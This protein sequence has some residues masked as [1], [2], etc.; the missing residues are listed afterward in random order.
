[1]PNDNP[2]LKQ[3]HLSSAGTIRQHGLQQGWNRWSQKQIMARHHFGPRTEFFAPMRSII[4]HVFS[5]W[6]FVLKLGALKMS[7]LII[8][9]PIKIAITWCYWGSVSPT[10]CFSSFSQLKWPLH[11]GPIMRRQDQIPSVARASPASGPF[12]MFLII[13]IYILIDWL[14]D[15]CLSI[16]WLLSVDL[17][18]IYLN[19]FDANIPISPLALLSSNGIHICRTTMQSSN[20]CNHPSLQQPGMYLRLVICWAIKQLGDWPTN[21]GE[22]GGFTLWATR[23]GQ[24]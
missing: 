5:D 17:Y 20:L 23:C 14:I 1:M 15:C 22:I 13:Y 19:M 6:G 11:W 18:L 21:P 2:S 12:L 9:F 24:A 3:L 10:S 16:L 8:P 4:D 7:W